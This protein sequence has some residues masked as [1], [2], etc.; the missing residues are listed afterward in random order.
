[1][2]KHLYRSKKDRRIA[3]VCGGLAEYFSV[4]PVFVRVA[5]LALIFAGGAGLVA[6]GA[7]WIA[8]PEQP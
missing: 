1:M 6:Y 7:F 4:D 8:A 3:G 2:T 5:F